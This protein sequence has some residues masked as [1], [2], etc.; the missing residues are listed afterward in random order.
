M[1]AFLPSS[2]KVEGSAENSLQPSHSQPSD[3][4]EAVEDEEEDGCGDA[5]SRGELRR[6]V[7]VKSA[8]GHGAGEDPHRGAHA[9]G[10]EEHQFA[11]AGT[12]D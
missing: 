1:L 10:S 2:S 11:A 4:E 5:V 6:S 3:R 8:C 7:L 9:E 12:F